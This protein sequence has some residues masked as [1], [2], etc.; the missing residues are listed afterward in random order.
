MRI[1]DFDVYKDLLREKS[2]LHLIPDQS[3]MLDS[4]LGPIAKKW[5]YF[6]LESMTV[7]VQGVPDKNLI[8][9]I[10]EAMTLTDT[11]FFRDMTPFDHVRDVVIPAMLKARKT[12]KKFRA[13][14]AGC[15]TGQEPY[16]LSMLIEE[17]K[18][19]GG[20]WK[21]EIIATDIAND[22]LDQARNG[23]YSQFEIQRGLSIQTVLQYFTQ[24][25]NKWALSDALRKRV[26]FQNYNLVNPVPF[27]D[28]FDV[29]M[30]RNV[31]SNFDD[32]IRRAVLAKLA[33]CLSADGF[34]YLGYR[35]S[36]IGLTEA[37]RPL[38]GFSGIYVPKDSPYAG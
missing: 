4:R 29:I 26:K 9:D 22:A 37:L 17:S 20:G 28:P 23:I 14:S 2:G 7:A 6:S 16:S 3:Y 5:G 31:I 30:C 15:A 1:T 10:I 11:S 38:P 32:D 19:N 25:G 13:W 8:S 33:A 35:E 24:D 27:T 12:K 36:A 21:T 34:L 18:M